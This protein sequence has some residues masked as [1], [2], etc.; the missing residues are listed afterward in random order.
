MSGRAVAIERVDELAARVEPHDWG[1]AR[2]RARAIATHWQGLVAERPR[3]FDGRVLLMHRGD[4]IDEGGKR[5]LRSAH[6]ETSFSAFIAWRDF[7]FPG[8]QVRN[9]FA[10]AALRGNDGGFVLAEMGAHTANAGK[11]Y[12]PAGTPD[13]DDVV[14]DAL[15]LEGSVSRELEE[16]T[17]LAAHEV[18]LAPGWVIVD[19]G[20]RLACMKSAHIDAPARDI[21][22]EIESRIA[23]Q[24][25]AEL[26]RMHVVRTR[27]DLVAGRM[28]DFVLA[29]LRHMLSA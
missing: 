24:E 3:L 8:A 9:C 10:M 19:A 21:A 25:D 17:G 20:P 11:I 13:L 14:G 23:R 26:R 5:V 2:E 12:F 16:E 1:F 6:F 7:G 18:S 4:V 29:Y 27:G 28:P 22:R 15:D